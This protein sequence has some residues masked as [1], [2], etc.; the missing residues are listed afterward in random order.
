MLM[1][2]PFK[3][4]VLPKG[5]W[6]P[7]GAKHEGFLIKDNWDD[8]FKYETTFKLVIVDEAGERTDIGYVKIGQFGMVEGQRS[9]NLPDK[10]EILDEAFFSLG[11]EDSYYEKLGKLNPTL[12]STIFIALKDVVTDRELWEKAKHEPVTQGSLLR[13]ASVSSVEGQ[14]R[15]LAQGGVRLTPFD[16][17]YALPPYDGKS[18]PPPPLTFNVVPESTPP[19]NVHVLIGRNGVGK[20]HTLNLMTK[21]ILGMP[22]SGTF[23]GAVGEV[24]L[25]FANLIS[26]SFSAFDSFDPI[27]QENVLIERI[28]YAYVGLKRS[29]AEPQNMNWPKSPE[30]LTKEFKDCF[31]ECQKGDRATRWRRAVETLESDPLM[32]EAEMT[33]FTKADIDKVGTTF[34][35]LS[36]GHKIV[37]LTLCHLV[38]KVEEKTMVLLDEPESHLHPPLLSAFIRALSDLLIDRNGVAIIATHSPV[39][40]QEVP[41]RCIWKFRRNG[42]V[43][44]VD[45]PAIETCGENV[46]T[47]TRE[48]FVL[49]VEEPGFHKLLDEAAKQEETFESAVRHFNNELGSE[50]IAMLRAMFVRK[51]S[52]DPEK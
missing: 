7:S 50:A 47:L 23:S 20:T 26:V 9:P 33:S 5:S 17:R 32:K 28:K 27:S 36:A 24:L 35:G 31:I 10:F 40:L 51:K 12:R 4:S 25:P 16:F 49:R 34:A 52:K 42:S 44:N 45:R 38:E 6:I 14:F 22:D 29:Q 30:E 15:R 48:V 21:A 41:R 39:V 11:A 2:N 3:F 37:L 1:S 19:T 8:W 46:G 13:G 18:P 43:V